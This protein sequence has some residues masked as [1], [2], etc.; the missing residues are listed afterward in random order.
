MEKFRGF[1][2]TSS[3]HIRSWRKR[4]WRHC[5]SRTENAGNSDAK[6]SPLVK[7]AAQHWVDHAQFEKVSSR[8]QE[9]MDDLF[10]SSKPHFAAWLQVHDIDECWEYFS[11]YSQDG[12][13]GSPLYYACILW[14]L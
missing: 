14:V 7:Y 13:V 9:G 4:A 2:S 1:V 3:Q 11:P 10:D 12:Y 6:V 8:V 5:F